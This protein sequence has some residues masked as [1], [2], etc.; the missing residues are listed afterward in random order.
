MANRPTLAS[1]DQNALRRNLDIIQNQ[2]PHASICAVIKADAYGHGS[3][4]IAKYLEATQSVAWF[5]VAHTEEGIVLREAGIKMPILVLGGPMNE[6][7]HELV[8]HKL[9]PVISDQTHLAPLVII[10]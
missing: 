8:A 4:P 5:A 3:T 1:I 6:E 7:Y 9:C 2:G 10:L